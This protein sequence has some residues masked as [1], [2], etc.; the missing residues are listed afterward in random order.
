VVARAHRAAEEGAVMS[1]NDIGALIAAGIIVAFFVVA[2]A[3]Y[4][5]EP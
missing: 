1:A 4:G 3:I 5:R 2:I